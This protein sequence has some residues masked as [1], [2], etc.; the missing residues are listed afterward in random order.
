M[1]PS[2]PEECEGNPVINWGLENLK[3]AVR[4]HDPSLSLPGLGEL[5]QLNSMTPKPGKER[6]RE[7]S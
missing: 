5:T 4:H 2:I 6:G 7:G 1:M 3:R